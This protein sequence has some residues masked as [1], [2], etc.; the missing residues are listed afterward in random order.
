MRFL[1]AGATAKIESFIT[2]LSWHVVKATLTGGPPHLIGPFPQ[3]INTTSRQVT[4]YLRIRR[5]CTSA[6]YVAAQ[7]EVPASGRNQETMVSPAVGPSA[8]RPFD[9]RR[10]GNASSLLHQTKC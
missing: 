9:A 6:I 10:L 8:L 3:S 4:K 1:S 5:R 2:S 7:Y